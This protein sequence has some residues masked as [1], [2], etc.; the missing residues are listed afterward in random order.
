MS[1]IFVNHTNHPSRVRSAEQKA[2]A[3]V[4]GAATDIPLPAVRAEATPAEVALQVEGKLE[5]ILAHKPTA[6]LC[7]R[8]FNYTVL[9][10]V[11]PVSALSL[12]KPISYPDIQGRPYSA[13]QTKESAIVYVE[14]MLAQRNVSLS[15]IFLIASDSVKTGK[16]Q[17]ENHVDNW[18]GRVCQI[19]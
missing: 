3:R 19:R 8:E 18:R 14:R 2:A 15:K 11:S 13:I 12:N 10:F 9:A 6:V 1:R 17:L 16:V 7:Q 5:E 4:Y